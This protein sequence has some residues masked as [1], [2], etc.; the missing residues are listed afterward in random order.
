LLRVDAS[1]DFAELCFDENAFEKECR[2]QPDL[3][4]PFSPFF[5]P[6][7]DSSPD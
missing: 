7:E 6:D 4:C 3:L 2:S 1:F 5:L